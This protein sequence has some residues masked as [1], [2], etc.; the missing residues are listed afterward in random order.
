MKF[1]AVSPLNPQRRCG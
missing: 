1:V